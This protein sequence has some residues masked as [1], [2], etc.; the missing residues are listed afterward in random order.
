[1]NV[2]GTVGKE[3]KK[4][5]ELTANESFKQAPSL[6]LNFLY[7]FLKLLFCNVKRPFKLYENCVTWI[8]LAHTLVSIDECELSDLINKLKN[9]L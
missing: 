6:H 2:A 3:C 4:F 5:M 1:V 9:D 8:S 7:D